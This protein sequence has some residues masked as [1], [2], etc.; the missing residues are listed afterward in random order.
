MTS[1]Y[2]QILIHG[3]NT[4]LFNPGA[5]PDATTWAGPPPGIVTFQSLLY[6][7]FPTPLFAAS[8]AV[9]GKQ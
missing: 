5:I 7:N 9:L 2:M 1:T 3:V 4:S 6:A 8:L